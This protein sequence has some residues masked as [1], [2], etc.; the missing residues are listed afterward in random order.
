MPYLFCPS[1]P[2]LAQKNQIHHIQNQDEARYDELVATTSANTIPK[3]VNKRETRNDDI[4]SELGSRREFGGA[5]E[6]RTPDPLLAKP[7]IG[8]MLL[9]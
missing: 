9:D 8:L 6:A 1:S 7:L 5:E 2:C 3:S 4:R